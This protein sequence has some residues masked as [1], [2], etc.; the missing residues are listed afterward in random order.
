MDTGSLY[1]VSSE[2]KRSAMFVADAL[3]RR[4]RGMDTAPAEVG[5]IAS[6]ACLSWSISTRNETDSSGILHFLAAMRSPINTDAVRM[7]V[8]MSLH[9]AAAAASAA[10]R[11]MA[12]A[13]SSEP[14]P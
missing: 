4:S 9:A 5:A 1:C 11:M 10:L 2:R 7:A 6:A 13:T 12:S 8:A 14:V 3:T